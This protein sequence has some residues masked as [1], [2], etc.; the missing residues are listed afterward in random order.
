MVGVRIR[1][2]LILVGLPL[3]AQTEGFEGSQQFLQ[4]YCG[5]CHGGKA[6]VGGF[7]LEKV[8]D[9]GSFASDTHSWVRLRTRIENHEMPPKGAPMPGLDS[10]EAFAKWVNAELKREAC[11]AGIRVGPRPIRRLNREEYT[12]TVQDL[13]DIHLDIGAS[14]PADG[15]GG[16]GFDNAAETLFLSPLHSEKYLETAKLAMDFAAKEYKSRTRIL[17]AKP[18]N[19]V[20]PEAAA[21]QILQKFL[22]R[23]FRRPV[24]EAELTSYLTLFR[25]ARAQG[26]EFEPAVFYMLRAALVSPHFLFRLEKGEYALASRLSYLLWGS[27]PDELL[28]DLA[29]EKKLNRPEVLRTLVDRMLR[30]ER[31]G[32]FAR[33]FI[34][35]WLH[36]RDLS[37]DK[38]PDAKLFPQYAKDEDLRGDIRLQPVYFFREILMRKLSLLNLIDSDFTIGTSHLEK[39]MGLKLPMDPGRRSQPQWVALPEGSKRGGILGMP[40]VLAISSYPYRTSPVLRGAFILD[41]I[42]GTPPPPPPANVPPLEEEKAGSA[43]K[44]VRERLAMHRANEPCAGC[45]SRI[46]PMG[47]ALENYDSVGRWRDEEGGKKVDSTAELTD[48]RRIEGPQELRKVLLEKKDLF[49]RNLTNKMLGYALGRGLTLQDSCTVDA[50]V[51]E[52]KQNDYSASKW[53]EA[54]VLSAPFRGEP[55]AA[56]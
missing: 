26:S 49:V 20:T 9:R 21:R 1:A 4:K 5:A 40:A 52:V 19:G 39:H 13:L 25:A 31:S 15:A 34:E 23:A 8:K 28:F 35:Q 54:I 48:G 42:L 38:M 50:I 56:K 46:D 18:G 29:K 6:A 41:S 44:S 24:E 2:A 12:A 33:R 36:T 17:V 11:S 22:P 55:E 37:G 30:N 14:L 10:R 47:F 53:I 3:L 27:L 7:Q 16:E 32:S 43:P 51:E 45:H